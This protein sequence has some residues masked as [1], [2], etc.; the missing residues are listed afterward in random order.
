MWLFLEADEN[1]LKTCFWKVALINHNWRLPFGQC[2]VTCSLG[3]SVQNNICTH[4]PNVST[5]F[6]FLSARSCGCAFPFSWY[7]SVLT[8]HGCGR[9]KA[10]PRLSNNWNLPCCHCEDTCFRVSFIHNDT[11]VHLY[12][13]NGFRPPFNFRCLAMICHKK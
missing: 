8:G 11:C 12:E 3:S 2:T 10:S 1:L 6:P 13:Q 7:Q 4:V 9:R 5:H